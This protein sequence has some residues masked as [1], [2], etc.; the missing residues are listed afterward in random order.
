M[1]FF[2]QAE[3]I[4]SKFVWKQRRPQIAKIF[5]GRKIRTVGVTLLDFRLYY[6]A[7]E[8]KIVWY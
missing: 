8:M 3:Q 4:I 6:K 1:V 7:T 5:L 2:T